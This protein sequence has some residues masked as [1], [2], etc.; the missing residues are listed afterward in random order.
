[1]KSVFFVKHKMKADN[2]LRMMQKQKAH[3]GVVK[4]KNGKVLGIVTLENLIE[5]VFG[6]ISDEHDAT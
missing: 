1:M 5:E 2:V 6:E 3:M 4:S